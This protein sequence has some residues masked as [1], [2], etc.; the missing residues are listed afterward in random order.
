MKYTKFWWYGIKPAKATGMLI[1][2]DDGKL[3]IWLATAP[4]YLEIPKPDVE[5]S[6]LVAAWSTGGQ[7]D[8][9]ARVG[10]GP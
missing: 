4:A 9:R 10:N 7:A 5:D 8:N 3:V 2:D 6:I 1:H